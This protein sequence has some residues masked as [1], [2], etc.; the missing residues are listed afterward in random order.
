MDNSRNWLFLKFE[1]EKLGNT[2][3]AMDSLRD[4][5]VNGD[6]TRIG[7]FPKYIKLMKNSND[8]IKTLTG[9][10]YI[11]PEDMAATASRAIA[12]TKLVQWDLFRE[13]SHSPCVMWNIHCTT[14]N[15]SILDDKI[16]DLIYC[17]ESI[18]EHTA[19]TKKVEKSRIIGKDNIEQITSLL[20]QC[21]DLIEKVAWI[22]WNEV[23]VI[24]QTQHKK[25][26][27]SFIDKI[28]SIIHT[29]IINFCSAASKYITGLNKALEYAI[30]WSTIRDRPREERI[31][32]N[33]YAKIITAIHESLE[34]DI[35]FLMQQSADIAIDQEISILK[36]NLERFF[37]LQ[38][39]YNTLTEPF[40][41]NTSHALHIWQQSSGRV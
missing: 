38:K 18:V 29:T 34:R 10:W 40:T 26:D 39:T 4:G 22:W 7:A 19:A 20:K 23:L 31:T 14:S 33:T 1:L 9:S 5:I 32:F 13:M 8:I 15:N 30:Q 11:I 6:F 16:F 21:L 28:P 35:S 24:L 37:L 2:L 17:L 25:I 12:Y 27:T 36:E 3:I 41:F